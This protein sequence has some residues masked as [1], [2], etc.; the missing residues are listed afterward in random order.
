MG[1]PYL[2]THIPS[3][4]YSNTQETHINSDMCS[5]TWETH[6]TSIIIPSGVWSPDPSPG[7]GPP[8]LVPASFSYSPA[9]WNLLDNPVWW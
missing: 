7:G 8:A 1:F 3:D 9:T 2:G 4:M 6:I 5:S